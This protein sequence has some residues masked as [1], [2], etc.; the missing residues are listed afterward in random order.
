[1]FSAT[2]SS[3][4]EPLPLSLMPGPAWTESRWAPAITTLSLLVPGSSAITLTCG[5]L[6]GGSTSMSRRRAG[7]RQRSPVGERSADDR[8]RHPFTAGDQRADD[9]TFTCRGVALVEDDD[10]FG[11]RG[12]RIDR[13][14]CERARPALDQGDVGRTSEAGEVA[15]LATA[16]HGVTWRGEVDVDRDDVARDG[17][18]PAPREGAGLVG[19]RSPA[20]AAGG[21]RRDEREREL[22]QRDVPPGGLERVDHVLDAAR[23]SRATL[24]RGC[25]RWRRQWPVAPL[26]ARG[27]PA[28]ARIRAASGTCCCCGWRKPAATAPPPPSRSAPPKDP[29]L[30]PPP[31][32]TDAAVVGH[33][34]M[35]TSLLHQVECPRTRS[36]RGALALR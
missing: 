9:Q 35:L 15:G 36:I 10:R 33:G 26:D 21:R 6:S 16:R 32:S 23:C 19:R 5:R 34:S 7:L 13:L 28:A 11:P 1:M 2:S 24:P 12:L 27:R 17:P 8:D 22:V 3:A 4:A 20:S 30:Q 14:D 29:G 31:R 25:R 18:E